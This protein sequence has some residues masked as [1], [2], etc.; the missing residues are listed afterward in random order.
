MRGN[1]VLRVQC[2]RTV[3]VVIVA[4]AVPPLRLHRA[5]CMAVLMLTLVCVLML[6]IMLMA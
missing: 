5:V 3:A 4:V 1:K 2:G 6:V